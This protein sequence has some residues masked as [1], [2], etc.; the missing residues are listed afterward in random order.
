LV[1]FLFSNTQGLIQLTGC[2]F[3]PLWRVVSQFPSY[4]MAFLMTE[5]RNAIFLKIV[6]NFTYYLILVGFGR[7]CAPVRC[8]HPYF[9]AHRHAKRGAARP[10]AHHSFAAFFF[11]FQK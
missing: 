11:V 1:T 2:R 6:F 3:S 4:L 9:W 5:Q 10:A 7:A 8:A